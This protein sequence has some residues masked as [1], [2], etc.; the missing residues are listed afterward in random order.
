MRDETGV[1]YWV[2]ISDSPVS[3]TKALSNV[4]VHRGSPEEQKCMMM[5]RIC[6]RHAEKTA[7]STWYNLKQINE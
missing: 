5:R 4:Q 7:F 3:H 2:L 1:L 6:G